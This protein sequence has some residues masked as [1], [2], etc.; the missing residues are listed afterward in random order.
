LHK[1]LKKR[2]K[3]K[4]KTKEKSMIDVGKLPGRSRM[5]QGI[6]RRGESQVGGEKGRVRDNTCRRELSKQYIGVP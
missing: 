3:K 1:A 6:E 5:I 4:E 2:K